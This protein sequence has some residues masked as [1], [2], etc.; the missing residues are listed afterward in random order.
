MKRK[1]HSIWMCIVLAAAAAG[2]QDGWTQDPLEYRFTGLYGQV[3]VGGR[4]AG[5]EFHNSRPLPSRL[6]FFYPVANSIDLS[7]DYWKRAESHPL[8]AGVSIN[9]QPV[10]WLG[11]EPW[12]YVLSPHKVTFH[13]GDGDLSYTMS[14]AF[15]LE[16]P[17]LVFRFTVVNSAPERRLIESIVDLSAVLRSCQTYA[18]FDQPV[19]SYDSVAGA[20]FARFTEP[21]TAGTSVFMLNVGEKGSRVVLPEKDGGGTP[22]VGF[23]QERYLDSRDSMT[24]LLL[25]GTCKNSDVA[26]EVRPD[27][28]TEVRL[29]RG[30]WAADVAAYDRY[31][32]KRAADGA[33]LKT[34][35]PWVDRSVPWA[36]ALLAANAHYLDGAIVPMPCPAEYNFFFTHDM[37]LTDLAAT[38]FDPDRVK[39]DLSYL[40]TLAKDSVIPHARYWKDDGF[41]TEY[42]AP[43]N[44]NHLWFVL[45][46]GSYLRHTGDTLLGRRLYA[47]LSKS[48]GSVLLRLRGDHLMYALAPDWWDIGKNE[49]SRAYMTVLVIR[50][51]REFAYIGALLNT[52][53]SGLGRCEVI[54]SAMEKSLGDHLWDGQSQY[55]TNFNGSKKDPHIYMGSLLAPAL[56]LLDSTR[57]GQLVRTAGQHLLAGGIGIRTVMPPDF[58]TDS[59]KAF[60]HF[61]GNEA[62]DPYLYANGGVWPH[63]NAWYTLALIATG[64]LDEAFRFYR[65]A[66][67]LDGIVHSPMGQP[68]FYEYRNSD[69]ASPIY[70]EVDKPSFLWAAGFTLLAGYRLLGLQ[71]NEWNLS[72]SGEL[73]SAV[74]TGRCVLEFGGRKEVTISGK[75]KGLSQFTADGRD[76]PSRVIPLDIR[77]TKKWL[78][79]LG[80]PQQPYLEHLNAQ[81][82]SATFDGESRRL[83]LK[84]SSFKGH[85]VM[86]AIAFTARIRSVS[87]DGRQITNLTIE[88]DPAGGQS[89]K[90][91]FAGID[92]TQDVVVTF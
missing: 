9:R 29:L 59:M 80:F 19:V 31:V 10:R 26:T 34:G 40:A 50:A 75:G 85:T 66:M 70:G 61:A 17:V 20:I 86:A 71:E 28:A 91:Q 65:T 90:L 38:A 49:G 67:T 3:E 1:I 41:K 74:D 25:I 78:V 83:H 42:C 44:W 22:K 88:G 21:Q 77:D 16:A 37:L 81:L 43:D 32:K 69:P 53:P 62:G 92:S 48:I 13:H 45:V 23:R 57:A 5:A 24:I 58:H 82:L 47:L 51:L 63:N 60:F 7:T 15:G 6:S 87:V 30:T 33:V 36:N 8:R 46:S 55:L 54:A 68:A 72:F 84:V 89:L 56:K 11:M 76:I 39:R 4:Y 12:G 73:P 64:R 14:Y 2:A 27:V 18:R 52:S 35:D 79:Y